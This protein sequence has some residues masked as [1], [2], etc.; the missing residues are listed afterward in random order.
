MSNSARNA[1]IETIASS[2]SSIGLTVSCEKLHSPLSTALMRSGGIY[3]YF[4]VPAIC[5]KL[6]QA[7]SKGRFLHQYIAFPY[8]AW[9]NHCS[10]NRGFSLEMRLNTNSMVLSGNSREERIHHDFATLRTG[11]VHL[12]VFCLAARRPARPCS[13]TRCWRRR[14]A[15]LKSC[16]R[17]A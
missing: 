9:D 12:H 13:L 10:L 14:T 17:W 2:L 3:R 1:H 7:S 11:I 5:R 16:T 15:T 6:L 4:N 8:S